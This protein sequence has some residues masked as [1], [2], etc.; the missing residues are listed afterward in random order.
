MALAFG[1]KVM[2]HILVLFQSTLW[3]LCRGGQ[4]A[5]LLRRAR[6][7]PNEIIPAIHRALEHNACGQPAYLEFIL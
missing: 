3:P 1:A 6:P 2:T 4:G 7:D 5:G